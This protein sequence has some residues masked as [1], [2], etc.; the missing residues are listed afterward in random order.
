MVSCFINL[1]AYL[2]FNKGLLVIGSRKIMKRYA[3]C[4]S[5][6]IRRRLV[7]EKYYIS[8]LSILVLLASVKDVKK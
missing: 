6:L 4:I 1:K 8:A 7:Y 3:H 2:I 5:L